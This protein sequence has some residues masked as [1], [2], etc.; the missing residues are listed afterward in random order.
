MASLTYDV[1]AGVLSARSS[2]G[3]TKIAVCQSG[4]SNS[5]WHAGV[6]A[7]GGP[8]QTS[9]THGGPIP[10]GIYHVKPTHSFHKDG[11]RFR[12]N[13]HPIEW[14]GGGRFNRTHLYIHP[15]GEHTD[16]CIAVRSEDYGEVSR[17]I[18]ED[19]GA[20]LIVQGGFSGE[21]V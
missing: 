16:G 12:P 2:S 7:T 19:G 15:M 13:W 4:F 6:R 1:F 10:P 8:K 18:D 14:A 11:G 3:T 17:I 21:I 20:T 9:H 5:V